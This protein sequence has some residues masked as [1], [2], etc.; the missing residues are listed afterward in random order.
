MTKIEYRVES[1][2]TFW[3]KDL[4]DARGKRGT[5]ALTLANG[6]LVDATTDLPLPVMLPTSQMTET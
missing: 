6:I 2:R 5:S 4:K 1:S 3:S